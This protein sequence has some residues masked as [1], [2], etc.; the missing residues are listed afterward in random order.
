MKTLRTWLFGTVAGLLLGPAMGFAQPAPGPTVVPPAAPAGIA[1][2]GM[3]AFEDAQAY[4][5]VHLSVDGNLAGRVSFF[6]TAGIRRPAQARISI[7]Q[8]RQIISTVRSDEFGRFQVVGLRPGVYSVV[9]AGPDG[10]G[11][12]SLRVLPFDESAPKDTNLFDAT[13]MPSSDL[14][15]LRNLLGLDGVAPPPVA[16]GVPFNAA[17]NIAAGGG[18]GGGADGLGLLAGAAAMA[19]GLAGAGSGTGSGGTGGGGGGTPA[20]PFQTTP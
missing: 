11:I 15:L 20:T 16:E 4:H 2:P 5:A 1:A 14:D 9:V 18:G 19:A 6:D 10:Y 3:P 17:P 12:Y 8:N 13:L 7:I